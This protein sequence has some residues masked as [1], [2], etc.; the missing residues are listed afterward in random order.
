MY[1]FVSDIHLGAGSSKQSQRTEDAFCRWLDMVAEDATAIYLMGDIFD[2][3]F[4]YRRVVPKGYVRVLSRLSEL[5]R[6]GVDVVFLTGNH[7]MWCYD[8]FEQECGVKIFRKPQIIDIAGY[9]YHLAHGDNLNIKDKPML[10][11]MNAFFRSS[12][13]RFLFSWLVHPDLAMR[14]GRWWS[15]KSRKSHNGDEITPESLKFLIEYAKSH[16]TT[17]SDVATYIFGHMHYPHYYRDEN[18]DVLFMSD[19]SG[20]SAIYC[21][22]DDSGEPQLKTFTIDET[23]S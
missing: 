8:Y 20:D 18:I 2:F 11:A 17:H 19:W 12:V 23:V 14:F 5:T 22:V 6:K 4:E 10:R 1:Y 21:V 9:K 7:D 15:G 3:W 13:A 16:H